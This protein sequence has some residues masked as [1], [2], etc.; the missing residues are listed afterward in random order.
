MAQR[1]LRWGAN[2]YSISQP[3]SVDHCSRALRP[4]PTNRATIAPYSSV[5]GVLWCAWGCADVRKKRRQFTWRELL[6]SRLNSYGITRITLSRNFLRGS[7]LKKLAAPLL[8]R[9]NLHP[10][11]PRECPSYFTS[12]SKKIP[13][14]PESIGKAGRN[15]QH[16]VSR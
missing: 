15:E 4:F 6:K 14:S 11:S 10:P 7:V 13:S 12:A 5:S 3:Q 2:S 8:G 16:T 9:R 1:C